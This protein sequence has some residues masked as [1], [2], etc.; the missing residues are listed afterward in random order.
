MVQVHLHL[1]VTN[2][3]S[4]SRG[5]KG[6]TYYNNLGNICDNHWEELLNVCSGAGTAAEDADGKY[7]SNLSFLN[8]NH[9]KLFNTLSPVKS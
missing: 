7:Q 1:D 9:A 5:S 8:F 6:T 3:S 4:D 2:F